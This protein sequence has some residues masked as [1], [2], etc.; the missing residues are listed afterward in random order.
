MWQLAPDRI[1]GVDAVDPASN[2]FGAVVDVGRIGAV[3]G[4]SGG[5]RELARRSTRSSRPREVC[6][7][8]LQ[9]QVDA[10]RVLSR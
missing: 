2:H 8:P 10:G 6:R 1:D 3:G 7:Q 5:D 4:L 9:R